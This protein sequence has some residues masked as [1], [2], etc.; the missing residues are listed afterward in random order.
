M[1]IQ[2]ERLVQVKA[3]QRRREEGSLDLR[4]RFRKIFIGA[5]Y[6]CG[7][8]RVDAEARRPNFDAAHVSCRNA[9]VAAFRPALAALHGRCDLLTAVLAISS[10]QNEF[11]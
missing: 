8:N 11:S 10:T 2:R 5:P 6:E 7:R 4:Q 1:L 3:A 9:I